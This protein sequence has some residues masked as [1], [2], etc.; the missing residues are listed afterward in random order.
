MSLCDALSSL[1]RWQ[2]LNIP[3]VTVCGDDSGPHVNARPGRLPW[4]ALRP[5]SHPLRRHKICI[6]R[7]KLP[8]S[9][10]RRGSCPPTHPTVR[11]SVTLSGKTN[12]ELQPLR[13]RL[14]RRPSTTPLNYDITTKQRVRAA[15]ARQ[16]WRS[17]DDG[18]ALCGGH[19]AADASRYRKLVMAAGLNVTGHGSEVGWLY[20]SKDKK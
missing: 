13:C 14:V 6:Y 9:A 12:Q 4:P 2:M 7:Q 11:C 16:C 19:G 20:G 18:G 17:G 15:S 5:S 1:T 3:P 8:L 10:C